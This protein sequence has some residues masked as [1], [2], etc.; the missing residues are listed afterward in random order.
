MLLQASTMFDHLKPSRLDAQWQRAAS[1]FAAWIVCMTSHGQLLAQGLMEKGIVVPPE[2]RRSLDTLLTP[3]EEVV[4]FIQDSDDAFV[5]AY[6]ADVTVYLKAVQSALEHQEFHHVRQF[7]IAEQLITEGLARAA[8][9]LNH[10]APWTHQTG[11]VVRGFH[12]RIDDSVQPY[13][14]VVPSSW[15]HGTGSS[16]RMDIW[17]HGRDNRLTELKFIDQRQNSPGPFTPEH[18][19]VLHPYGR[20]CNAFKFAGEVDVLEAMAHVRSQYPIDQER[21]AVRGF[22]M[23]GAGC[24]HLAVHHAD[25]WVAAAP[26]AGFA[27]SA[28]YLGLWRK[29]PRPNWFET[30]LWR[31]YDADAYALNLFHLPTLAYSGAADKQIQAARMMEAALDREG[32]KLA[33]VIGPETGHRYH[34]DSKREV[35]ERIDHIVR[36]GRQRIPSKV[37]MTTYTLKYPRM[38]WVHLHGLERHWEKAVVRAE[39]QEPDAVH[40]HA[41]NI[42]ALSLVMPAGSC[43]LDLE[44]TPRVKINGQELEVSRVSADRSWKVLLRQREGKWHVVRDFGAD[45]PLRKRPGLQ[46]PIDDAFMDR[47]VMVT[48]SGRPGRSRPDRWIR[49]EQGRLEKEW[50]DQFRGEPLSVA[51]H[52]FDAS[53]WRDAHW[54]LF[55]TPQNNAMIKQMMRYLPIQWQKGEWRVGEYAFDDQR[56]LPVMV[57]PNPLNPGKYIVLNSGFTFRG[58]GSNAT[59]VPRLPDYAVIDTRVR[60]TTEMPGG[61]VLA[62]FFDEKWQLSHARH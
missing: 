9:L 25:K 38:H 16:F 39:L 4:A 43:P 56:Y 53:Q 46:G 19:F 30:K 29:D 10:K 33:H 41:E 3:L 52:S 62:G 18:A 32:M 54:I 51:D 40:I 42:T 47:F 60:P 37:R 26:G 49:R 59:Q 55:G 61:I 22:S 35:A 36:L 44:Q 23:G 14:L 45:V 58:Y 20:F 8:H 57:F 1:L 17:L 34:P 2:V 6:E 31:L 48:P 13:G 21:V 27:E 12:S 11:L 28:D 7:E 15:Q 24:W 5:H 50:R